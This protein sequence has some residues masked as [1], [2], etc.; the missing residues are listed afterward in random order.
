[1]CH[2]FKLFGNNMF[3]KTLF[4]FDC[5]VS[6]HFFSTYIESKPQLDILWVPYLHTTHLFELGSTPISIKL[7]NRPSFQLWLSAYNT[8]TYD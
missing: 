7:K 8:N 4:S 2:Q 3:G 5:F 6:L 1:M